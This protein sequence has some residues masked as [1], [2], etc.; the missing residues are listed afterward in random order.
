M[1]PRYSRDCEPV[2]ISDLYELIGR[3]RA[4]EL[5]EKA[6]ASPESIRR[7]IDIP[8]PM[9]EAAQNDLDEIAAK[10]SAKGDARFALDRNSSD[11]LL[12][13]LLPKVANYIVSSSGDSVSDGV[14]RV[15]WFAARFHEL[16]KVES[17][18]IS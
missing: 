12:V 8:E 16:S 10:L 6:L 17:G 4:V 2:T 5:C 1:S 9:T 13:L 7:L 11:L 18:G 15:R 3:F 14:A